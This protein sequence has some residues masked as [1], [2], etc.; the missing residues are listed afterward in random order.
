MFMAFLLVSP[1]CQAAPP[2]ARGPA[3]PRQSAQPGPSPSVAAAGLEAEP[4]VMC[5]RPE[6][7]WPSGFDISRAGE[8]YY[9]EQY[10][11][12]IRFFDPATGRDR[13]WTRIGPLGD[14]VYEQGLFGVLLDPEWPEEPWLYAFYTNGDPLE[15]RLVRLRKRGDG[16][17]R[18]ETLL[19]L[20]ARDFH[21][22]GGLAFGSDGL[23]YATTGESNNPPL[24][25]DTARPEGKVLRINSD[26]TIPHDNPFFP[27]PVLSYGHRNGYGI[28][29]DPDGGGLWQTENG[30]DCND[31]INFIQAGHNYG[32]GAESRCPD[33]NLS[34][35]DIT[36]PAWLYEEIVAPTGATFCLDCGLGPSVEGKLLIG[37]F[38]GED[39]RSL[40]LNEERDE[41]VSEEVLYR[42]TSFVLTLRR[43]PDGHILF[44]DSEGIYRLVSP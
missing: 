42:H 23:L 15:N 8:I 34:G 35:R 21:N 22:G 10:T 9:A 28:A 41:I 18:S 38:K 4:V 43:A 26:G 1:A 27:S 29:I 39:I 24:A 32:W 13:L 17:V 19:T 7:C 3:P 25:Q 40:S 6:R 2:A 37:T 12:E 31:E 33:T 16:S 30:P 14:V 36:E 20:A 11:G 5:G 44:S